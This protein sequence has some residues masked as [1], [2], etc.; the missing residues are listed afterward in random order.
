MN[1]RNEETRVTDLTYKPAL[2]LSEML[3]A[4]QISAL[5]VMRATLARIDQTNHV[6]AIVSLRGEAALLAEATAADSAERKGW[7]HGIPIAIKDLA[8]AK[9]LPTS[10]GSPLFA[11]Q[12]AE[13]DDIHVA[14]LRAAGAI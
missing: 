1:E 2:E 9:G 14:R 8:N 10:M 11:G 4:G 6:N 3:A 5:E 7:L 12:M 13:T